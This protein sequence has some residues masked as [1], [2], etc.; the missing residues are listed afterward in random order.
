MLLE[1]RVAI[2]LDGT[3][4]VLTVL[5]VENLQSSEDYYLSPYYTLRAFAHAGL[6]GDD[7]GAGVLS[8]WWA[9]RCCLRR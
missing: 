2:L 6:F 9:S 3:P 4:C 8:R 7:R 5:F 1:G